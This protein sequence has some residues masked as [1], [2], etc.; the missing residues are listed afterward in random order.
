MGDDHAG[1]SR[2]ELSS[3][4][5]SCMSMYC[6]ALENTWVGEGRMVRARLGGVMGEE[7]GGTGVAL[8]LW[9]EWVNGRHMMGE[10]ILYA[11]A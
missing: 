11:R 4:S 7:R 8:R 6:N 9:Y 5:L 10:L 1:K 2:T 3:S